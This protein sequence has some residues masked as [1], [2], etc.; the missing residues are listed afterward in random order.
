MLSLA[1]KSFITRI[2]LFCPSRRYL[3]QLSASNISLPTSTDTLQPSQPK[4]LKYHVPRNTRGNLPV[5]SDVRNGG[6][7]YLVLIRNIEGNV[8]AL[9]KDLTGSL[10][11]EGSYEASRLN[12]QNSH[13]KHLIISGGRWKN[14]VIEW[15]KKRGF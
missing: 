5:Y 13:S 7:R 9:G 10:F 1:R 3:Q 2:P 11:A 8:D 6:G 4:L 14:E 15:L 12:V